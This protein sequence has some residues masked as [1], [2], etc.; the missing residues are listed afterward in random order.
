VK[1][2]PVGHR[3]ARHLHAGYTVTAE[4]GEKRMESAAQTLTMVESCG[5]TVATHC[6]H[7]DQDEAVEDL[8]LDFPI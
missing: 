1:D 8:E 3:L 5:W 7:P 4:A 2:Q 6:D